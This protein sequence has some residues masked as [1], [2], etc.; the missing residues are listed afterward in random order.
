MQ[1]ARDTDFTQANIAGGFK[2]GTPDLYT[3]H[4]VGDFN[5]ETGECTMQLI[6]TSAH[7]ATYPHEGSCAQFGRHFGVPYSSPEARKAAE[8]EGWKKKKGGCG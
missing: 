8:E 4:H 5:P 7:R 6:K 1:G 3:W 2:G